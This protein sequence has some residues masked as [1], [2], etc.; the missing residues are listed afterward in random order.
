MSQF[1]RYVKLRPCILQ[2]L[3]GMKREFLSR[4]ILFVYV[5]TCLI[6]FD[7]NTSEKV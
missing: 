3:I 5:V 7:L 1:V 2:H 6:P 4:N